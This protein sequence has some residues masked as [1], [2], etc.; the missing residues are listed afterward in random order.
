[1]LHK[2]WSFFWILLFWGIHTS[3]THADLVWVVFSC[4]LDFLITVFVSWKRRSS[5][6][7]QLPL[8]H[9]L[10]HKQVY[11]HLP[12]KILI[13]S[14]HYIMRGLLY[15]WWHLTRVLVKVRFLVPL[16]VMGQLAFVAFKILNRLR[17]PYLKAIQGARHNEKI[18]EYMKN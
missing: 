1:M 3:L 9:I 4:L 17:D 13:W 12:D 8:Q 16:W 14:L 5:A 7:L 11:K 15:A 10:Q 6:L 2:I 18:H